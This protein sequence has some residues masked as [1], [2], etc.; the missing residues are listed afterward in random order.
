MMT[1]TLTHFLFRMNV[2]GYVVILASAGLAVVIT[3]L[4]LWIYELVAGPA[5][6]QKDFEGR[7]GNGF[8]L[9]FPI[10]LYIFIRI[11]MVITKNIGH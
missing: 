1:L 6:S 7:I 11:G 9:T 5:R 3:S 4:L 2:I 10:A 8:C